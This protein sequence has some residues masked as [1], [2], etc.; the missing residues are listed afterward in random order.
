MLVDYSNEPRRD[1]LC[2]DLQSFYASVECVERGLDPRTAL[3]VVMSNA[4]NGG[5]LA[6]AASPTAK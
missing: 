6:L 5:G 1:I 2:L 3:L 4:D